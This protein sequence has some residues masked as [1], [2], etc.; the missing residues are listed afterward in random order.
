ME[1]S[2]NDSGP[3]HVGRVLE[4]RSVGGSWAPEPL[5]K[6]RVGTN[7][8]SSNSAGGVK[9]DCD[10]NVWVTGNFYTGTPVPTYLY[11]AQRIP[12]GGNDSVG[13]DGSTSLWLDYDNN[14]RNAPKHGIGALAM[15]DP[16]ACAEVVDTAI[17]FDE[18]GG[19]FASAE[20]EIKNT[21]TTG[22]TWVSIIP[23]LGLDAV[24]IDGVADARGQAR[25]QLGAELTMGQEFLLDGITLK[26]AEP[27]A[28][29]C[30]RVV[31]FDADNQ[32]CCSEEI[33][34][35][36]PECFDWEVVGKPKVIAVSDQ[37]FSTVEICLSVTNLVDYAFYEYQVLE[38]LGATIEPFGPFARG[39][40]REL[41]VTLPAVQA[42]GQYSFTLVLHSENYEE[43]CSRT[44]TV[45]IPGGSDPTDEGWDM[46]LT[47]KVCGEKDKVAI[48]N[49]SFVNNANEEVD[50]YARLHTNLQNSD[51]LPLP[52]N[53]VKFP[54]R[55]LED[56]L[57]KFPIGAGDQI[58][59]RIEIY[60]GD[61]EF[62]DGQCYA[63]CITIR[64]EKTNIE[65]T[66]CLRIEP[67]EEIG[68]PVVV[69]DSVD[70][71]GVL[72]GA[73]FDFDFGLI[74]E[75]DEEVTFGLGVLAPIEGIE[76]V[77]REGLDPEQK[78][79]LG[80]GEALN[81]A[82]QGRM[83]E[84]TLEK[85]PWLARVFSSFVI[86]A[87]FDD[88]GHGELLGK[89]PMIVQTGPDRSE[90]S[91]CVDSFE[92]VSLPGT[93]LM[94]LTVSVNA[95][96]SV[97][98]IQQMEVGTESWRDVPFGATSDQPSEYD[99]YL[100]DVGTFEFYLEKGEVPRAIY[101]VTCTPLDPVGDGGAGAANPPTP[102]QPVPELPP[103][104]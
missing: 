80:A 30:F 94:K 36:M 103:G 33:C 12:D 89:I 104:L 22:A 62:T 6:Y 76:L 78:I 19:T 53:R 71:V 63:F 45:E 86:T 97:I 101:R 79:T 50:L 37:G 56:D 87:K 39:E 66:E 73:A 2:R 85:Y 28:E 14:T 16:C 11:G 17:H 93:D 82:L 3:A 42:G 15:Y 48:A 46:T 21:S 68:N 31:L 47:D 98:T 1:I 43:C 51:C 99:A 10:G 49:L 38:N 92:S 25:K 23:G 35:T 83:K 70:S 90:E 44:V 59:Q 84:G 40:T 75:S 55:D 69:V 81:V 65:R 32:T 57:V 18:E 24:C 64:D 20:L 41:K 72:V 4:Y 96:N 8:S 95:P 100:L 52:L 88:S 34:V 60:C 7:T 58:D 102:Q 27:G 74:N 5:T 61:L 91:V 13:I 9:L 77:Y 29:V 67:C 54:G 26:G